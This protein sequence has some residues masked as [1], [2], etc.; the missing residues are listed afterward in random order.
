VLYKQI[1]SV[2]QFDS[3]GDAEA[4]LLRQE[5]DNY[6]IVGDS[7]FISPVPLDALEH[8]RLIH[9]SDIWVI[10]PSGGTV[11]VIK[12]FEYIE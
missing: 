11:S 1:T 6:K 4:Y 3:Y 2:E 9:G 8:Y 7:P 12:I 5:S 10:L